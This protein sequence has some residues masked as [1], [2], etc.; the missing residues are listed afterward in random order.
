MADSTTTNLLLTKPEVGASTDTWGSKINTD[1]DTIDAL[2]DAGPL[3]KVTKGGTGVGTSTGSGNNVLSTSPTLVTP[4][5]GT[6]TSVTLTNAT[7]L[8]I[9]TGV[10]GLGT[11]VA[12]A[13]A[14]NVG[15]AGAP[16]VNGG[17]L[18]TPSSGTVTNLTGTASINING[19]VGATTPTTG[20]FTTVAASSS[21][22]LS[23][24]TANGVTYLNGSKVLTSGSA[25]TFDGNKLLT[26][27]LAFNYYTDAYYV[28]GTISN[29]SSSNSLYVNGNAGGYLLLQGAG[30][31]KQ[32]IGI[33]GSNAGAEIYF[34]N[35]GSETMRLTST[36]LG[37]GTSSPAA[38]LHVSATTP[39]IRID[40]TAAFNATP[41]STLSFVG[42]YNAGGGLD[43]FAQIA[44]V[45]ANATDGDG[46]A[47]L[48]FSTNT[49]T[50]NLTEK[51]RITSAGNVGIG[52]SSPQARLQ[53]LDQIKVSSADQ[54][55]G[56]VALGDGS[57]TSVNVG[58]GRW[59]G[60]TNAAGTGGMGYFSQGVGNSGGHYFYTGDA[61]AGSQTER[62]RIPPA[63]GFQS[64]TTISV[65]N[66]SPSASGAGIT[67]PA[68][69]S[70]STNA[71]TLDDYEEG[72]WTP[73]VS[74]VTLSSASGTYTKIGRQVFVAFDITW[75]TNTNTTAIT[76]A[77][78]PFAP[79]ANSG[80]M[81]TG[82]STYTSALI[83]VAGSGG[84]ALYGLAG[85]P[86]SAPQNIHLS[87]L[88]LIAS[89]TYTV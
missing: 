30:N 12:T 24:G 33:S 78:L 28:D 88:R 86:A 36:G 77:S 82:Y 15:S 72:T 80:V 79:T 16:V 9:A 21:V 23:G 4:I 65:G 85:N 55:A 49:S 20:A 61:A 3:L 18:G 71:N 62:A 81:S 67:F 51:M 35:N 22:T 75:P 41:T 42:V 57:S 14:V 40:A 64:V 43:S 46:S 37:I 60:S 6:P 7:G 32:Q 68:T 19:T 89:A 50:A 76:I 56:I 38:K 54:S 39:V 59:N 2:F 5:L 70:A 84:I 74:G 47:F 1:L 26:N 10:S 34:K 8:P 58:I 69:Q 83:G 31:Q 44:G 63:G 48:K 87:G 25:L 13:L 17:A 27:A 11:G 45:K 29:Y 73:T 52:T 66:A 53:V